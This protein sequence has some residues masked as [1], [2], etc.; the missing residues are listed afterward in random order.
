MVY[1][2]S[3]KIRDVMSSDVVFVDEKANIEDV[4]T[5][6]NRKNISGAPVLNSAGNYVGTITRTDLLGRQVLLALRNR[7]AL[8]DLLVK[9]IMTPS[10]HALPPTA[11]LLDALNLM[12]E[13]KVHRIFVVDTSDQVVGVLSTFDLV[14][15][16]QKATT[17]S[18][19]PA[20]RELS[21]AEPSLSEKA[22][23]VSTRKKK[24]ELQDLIGL[25]PRTGSYQLKSDLRNAINRGR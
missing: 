20:N 7:R 15:V 14:S 1:A 22:E 19:G 6:F 24:V 8:T 16:I 18:L 2:G 10:L 9:D 3:E 17:E 13:K 23:E 5:L 11:K 21:G 12:T 4:A 25:S